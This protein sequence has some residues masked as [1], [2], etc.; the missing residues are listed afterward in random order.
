MGKSTEDPKIKESIKRIND[1]SDDVK[2]IFLCDRYYIAK[3]LRL[4]R[5]D[6]DYKG[7]LNKYPELKIDVNDKYSRLVAARS[8]WYVD[9]Y[10]GLDCRFIDGPMN[11]SDCLF[12]V[13]NFI[14]FKV[15]DHCNT[16]Y[17]FGERYYT[18]S[19][20]NIKVEE[21]VSMN[22]YSRQRYSTEGYDKE[23]DFINNV[24]KM[25]S[26]EIGFDEEE[27]RCNFVMLDGS[28]A[29]VGCDMLIDW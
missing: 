19:R 27:A 29:S 10:L 6:R 28:K 9:D 5:K 21:Y 8:Y 12:T 25:E 4:I 1:N 23:I 13:G 17:E 22:R 2:F 11:I 20:V 16:I 26:V 24:K 15:I 7:Y 18:T 3:I 14:K